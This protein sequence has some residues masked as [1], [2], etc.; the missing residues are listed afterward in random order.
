MPRMLTTDEQ[1]IYFALLNEEVKPLIVTYAKGKLSDQNFH[2][3][4]LAILNKI[5]DDILYF[6]IAEY[7]HAAQL[8][9]NTPFD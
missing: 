6:I 4:S 5:D 1:D 3:A 8:V 7:I 2:E 9:I